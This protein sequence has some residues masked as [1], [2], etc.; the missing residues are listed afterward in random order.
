M[1]EVDVELAIGRP[2]NGLRPMVERYL[3]YRQS[4]VTLGVHRGLPSR[5][6]TLIVSLA[7][8]I[9]IRRMPDPGQ[10]P[11]SLQALV[12]GMHVVPALIAQDPAQSGLH[13]ELNPLGVR[14]L[15]GV[16]AEELSSQVIELSALP[17]NWMKALPDRLLEA[18]TWQRQ[19]AILD[20]VLGVACDDNAVVAPEVGHAWQRILASGGDVSVTG[21]ATEVGW[22]RHH[23]TKRFSH[24]FGLSPKQAARVIRFER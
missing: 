14:A 17:G 7:D 6:V 10:A 9:R 18:D 3:G 13:V 22:S 8:P 21:L 24:A 11:A 20:Q 12:G 1:A 23:L 16:S 4:G 19:F 15:L 5:N 2:A